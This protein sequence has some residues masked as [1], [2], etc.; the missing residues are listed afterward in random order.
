LW[1]LYKLESE[2]ISHSVDHFWNYLVVQNTKI[3]DFHLL[4]L[5]CWRIF[6]NILI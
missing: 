1:I 4:P 3:T 6:K 2:D 5:K